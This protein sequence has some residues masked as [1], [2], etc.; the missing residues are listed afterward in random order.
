MSK[1]KIENITSI[2]IGSGET[3]HYG[4]DFVCGK[5]SDGDSI[6]GVIDPR[7]VLSLLGEDKIDEWVVAI[8]NGRSTDQIV[9]QYV[10]SATLEVYSRRIV[11]NWVDKIKPTDTLKEYIHDGIGRPYIPGS[12]IKGAIRTAVLANLCRADDAIENYVKDVD[13]KRAAG[14][15]E[16]RMFGN[17]ANSDV[18]RF[19]HVG[20]A[21]FG[22]NYEAVVRMV[23]INERSRS[24][25]WDMSKSQ[26]LEVLT[27]GDESIFELR[28][29]TEHHDM[30]KY[31]V[32]AFPD[33]MRTLSDLFLTVNEHTR[34]L[35]EQEISYWREREDI[36][37]SG[38]VENYLKKLNYIL[39][40][41]KHCKEGKECIL[42]IG[43]GSG[44]RFITGAWTETWKSFKTMIVPSARR[45]NKK[46]HGYQFPKTR[47][48]DVYCDLLGFVKLTKIAD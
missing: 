2:H 45:D 42:R 12:S 33:C 1:V 48:V 27:P 43:S 16:K 22:K 11:Q 18:F 44:W 17:D 38:Q 21:Y 40:Q 4:N 5:D 25:F 10:P 28:I 35:M 30:A 23:N 14:K 9:K 41:V 20:D 6:I 32:N 31:K 39:S 24:G 46:Y 36:D 29:K 26:L 8:E 7:K 15:I 34:L 3:Y 47:R 19:L 37:D 13:I